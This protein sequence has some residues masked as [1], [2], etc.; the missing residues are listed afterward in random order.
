[1]SEAVARRLITE[2]SP[3]TQVVLTMGLIGNDYLRQNIRRF[4]Q[5]ARYQYPMLVLTDLDRPE[6]CPLELL[7]EWI[8]DLRI[9]PRSIDTG[10]GVG[11]RIVDNG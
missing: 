2:Y 9:V 10:S 11:N 1:M 4:N 5:I 7:R 8:G 6:S 3:N